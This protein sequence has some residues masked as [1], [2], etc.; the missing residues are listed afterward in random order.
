MPRIVSKAKSAESTQP[1]PISITL[2]ISGSSLSSLSYAY[3]EQMINYP[4]SSGQLTVNLVNNTSFNAYIQDYVCTD[5]TVFTPNLTPPFAAS[6]QSV[7]FTMTLIANQLVYFGIFV[8][9][10]DNNK[11]PNT[12]I[13]YC[14]PQ[15]GNDP[16]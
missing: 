12:Q 11:P 7:T 1:S 4:E 16:D 15:V 8:S 3:S 9:V 2:T 5:P 14:D 10:S 6:T 13:I